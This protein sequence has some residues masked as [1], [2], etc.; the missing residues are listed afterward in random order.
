MERAR[1]SSGGA[2]AST[3]GDGSVSASSK[4]MARLRMPK[5]IPAHLQQRHKQ[6]EQQQQQQQIEA[7]Q[8]KSDAALHLGQSETSSGDGGDG[9]L[10][11]MFM[12][13]GGSSSASGISAQ[14]HRD[15]HDR[16]MQALEMYGREQ[17]GDEWKKITAFV[18][19]RSIEEV[20]L[21]GRQYLQ[22]LVHQL[23]GTGRA[24]QSMDVMG[25]SLTPTMFGSQSLLHDDQ[26]D[27]N[28]QNH[29]VF[30]L[31]SAS[32]AAAK[33]LKQP[34]GR[35]KSTSVRPPMSS[36]SNLQQQQHHHHQQYMTDSAFVATK[37]VQGLASAAVRKNGASANRKLK[38]WTFEE[39]KIFENALANWSSDKPYSWNKIATVL[40]G[41]TAK[42]ARNRYEKL[43][44]DVTMI[45]MS[46]GDDDLLQLQHLRSAN[47]PSLYAHAL[48]SS[49]SSSRSSSSLSTRISPPPPIQVS[50]SVAAA[51]AGGASKGIDRP[52]RVSVYAC[53]LAWLGEASRS[54]S[55]STDSV[56]QSVC[57][58]VCCDSL[59][60]CQ[61]AWR[62]VVIA[63]VGGDAGASSRK[64]VEQLVL[65]SPGLLATNRSASGDTTVAALSPTFLDFLACE[66]KP[67]TGAHDFD[68]SPSGLASSLLLP[69]PE[70][71]RRATPPSTSSA[72]PHNGQSADSS[73]KTASGAQTS[74]STRGAGDNNSSGGRVTPS[75][76][77]TPRIWQE[78]LS[79]D[80][81]FDAKALASAEDLATDASALSS[82]ASVS[83]SI[84]Q[85][86]SHVSLLS[87]SAPASSSTTGTADTS[88][89]RTDPLP[90]D[91]TQASRSATLLLE[92]DEPMLNAA[93]HD[94][95]EMTETRRTTQP[96]DASRPK[97]AR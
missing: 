78:F 35:G 2:S 85:D 29:M 27:P 6:Q 10:T 36:K 7:M 50:L 56:A 60:A 59:C 49:S 19:T 57:M 26:N 22:Q 77:A 8:L 40:P 90:Q 17:S 94:D 89:R 25:F 15:E 69:S 21:H 30:P 3:G 9:T 80:F 84:S 93:T 83:S 18:Q 43:V 92:C 47:S 32:G 12:T 45:E 63:T 82:G 33:A 70:Y 20:R 5:T 24:L 11:M 62:L 54:Y 13:S 64:T 95:V 66:E 76:F 67:L 41:K 73:A 48:H 34:K 75:G 16:F 53:G 68:D 28:G 88:T 72:R 14:W 71:S 91:P 96:V 74:T 97:R 61:R 86:M 51:A 4:P 23:S 1:D 87:S 58:C 39:D 55:T 81:K 52:L 46:C 79:D 42:D 31:A 44:G 38:V 37:Q 65:D